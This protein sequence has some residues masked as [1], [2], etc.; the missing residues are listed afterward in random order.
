MMSGKASSDD[1]I[2]HTDNNGEVPQITLDGLW[3]GFS[4]ISNDGQYCY[5]M[6]PVALPPWTDS[7]E[8]APAPEPTAQPAPG[9]AQRAP[10]ESAKLDN[11]DKQ[12]SLLSTEAASSCAPELRVLD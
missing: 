4:E 2:T 7:T 9:I 1:D 5:Q 12:L 11:Q 3:E 6:F 10:S 8:Q